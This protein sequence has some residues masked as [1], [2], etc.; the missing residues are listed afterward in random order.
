MWVYTTFRNQY[1]R[2]QLSSQMQSQSLFIV[3]INEKTI[4]IC[5]ASELFP[6]NPNNYCHKYHFPFPLVIPYINSRNITLPIRFNDIPF[7]QK[8]RFH[9]YV[10][11]IEGGPQV[12]NLWFLSFFPR[13]N[14]LHIPLQEKMATEVQ[15]GP[16]DTI[17]LLTSSPC[18]IMT[19]PV[20]NRGFYQE[21]NNY[22][23]K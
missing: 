4:L 14:V 1:A 9:K 6:Q 22:K 2:I 17:P 23:S 7:W 21:R 13:D 15:V 8:C 16:N 18:T 20:W 5:L 19:K 10:G 3:E 12:I 11:I